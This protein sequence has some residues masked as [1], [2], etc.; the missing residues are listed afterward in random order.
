MVFSTIDTVNS[1]NA[2]MIYN[3]IFVLRA[4]LL[5]REGGK[6]LQG[7]NGLA[8]GSARPW[9]Q[10]WHSDPETHGAVLQKSAVVKTWVFNR[11]GP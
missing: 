10:T 6:A 8:S 2:N 9:G 7:P 1:E 11:G 5:K 4:I 3:Q